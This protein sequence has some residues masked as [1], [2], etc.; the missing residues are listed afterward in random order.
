MA[1]VAGVGVRYSTQYARNGP[2][3]DDSRRFVS[4]VVDARS[5][6]ERH[7]LLVIE[8]GLGRRSY[9]TRRNLFEALEARF[10]DAERT[11]E[12][13][14]FVRSNI[15]IRAFHLAF[16][17]EIAKHDSLI[18]AYLHFLIERIGYPIEV[19]TPDR[20]LAELE[21]QETLPWS[22]S[23]RR[24]TVASLG[25][26]PLHFELWSA[27]ACGVVPAVVPPIELVAFYVQSA[28]QRSASVARV[29][30]LESLGFSRESMVEALWSCARRGWFEV[31]AMAGIVHVER[32][33]A[34]LDALL[35]DI[36]GVSS[37][38]TGRIVHGSS[39]HRSRTLV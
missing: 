32:R 24:R 35:R 39:Y 4:L 26:L 3:L 20:F 13:G 15:G 8:N 21:R 25:M 37:S 19:A 34:T 38:R 17:A 28:L 5:R 2:L 36:D 7:R 11:A 10:A 33:F 29:F 30:E 9:K 31:S 23:V 12:L 1:A 18:S 22:P 16:L 14:R 27:Q 6:I